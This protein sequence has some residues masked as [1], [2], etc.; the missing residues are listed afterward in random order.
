[1][2]LFDEPAASGVSSPTDGRPVTRVK[3]VVA[4][5][6]SGFH[7][8]APNEGVVTVGGTLRAAIETVVRRSVPLTAA[9]RTDR[10]VHA[11][12]QVVTVD[13]PAD[14]ELSELRHAVNKL[15]GGSIVVREACVV[16]P[17]FDARFTARSRVYRYTI[18]NQPVPD[19]FLGRTAWW[20][21]QPLDLR[22]M[23]LACDALIGEHDFTSF[24]RRPKIRA[25]ADEPSLRRRV[26]DA[27]WRRLDADRMA[28][29]QFEIEATAFCHQMVRSIVGTIVDVGRGSR[30]AGDMA[31][32]LRGR[33]RSL[34]GQLAPPQGLC[35]WKVRY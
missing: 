29:L 19:P 12:G 8:F 32:I 33:H 21:E 6:G 5:D 24:C 25:P 34:A 22:S 11:W 3:L 13:L 26:I 30:R 31:A 2:T 27:R 9:G 18:V 7:G 35:L 1:M 23:Q 20:I 10:G 16:E 14:V 17:D 4:Y 15:C 28:V